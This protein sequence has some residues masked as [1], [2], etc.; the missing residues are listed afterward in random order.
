MSL[1]SDTENFVL[2]SSPPYR[3]SDSELE[4]IEPISVT[5]DTVL[6]LE[7]V[8]P[9]LVP[10]QNSKSNNFETIV[11][12]R[13]ERLKAFRETSQSNTS[14]DKSRDEIPNTRKPFHRHISLPAALFMER[15][16]SSK[17]ELNLLLNSRDI[18]K[19][20]LKHQ[21]TLGRFDSVSTDNTDDGHGNRNPTLGKL[22]PRTC[23]VSSSSWATSVSIDDFRECSFDEPEN[24]TINCSMEVPF[25]TDL[26]KRGLM[27]RNLRRLRRQDTV[28]N[29]APADYCNS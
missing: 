29:F 10:N 1:V 17:D 2:E 27:M 16:Y 26:E 22:L 19:R 20:F 9:D 5:L 23:S 7:P 14:I 24:K 12:R 11:N 4:S 18:K 13:I 21:H 8:I 6:N 25:S 3:L 15:C 28:G